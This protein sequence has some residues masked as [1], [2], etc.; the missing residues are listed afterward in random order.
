MIVKTAP[1]GK[2]NRDGEENLAGKENRLKFWSLG[3]EFYR[4]THQWPLV[5]LTIVTGCLVGWASQYIWP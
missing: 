5:L 4:F 1:A 3:D 2:E